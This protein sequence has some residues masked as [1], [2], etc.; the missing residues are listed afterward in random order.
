MKITLSLI[1]ITTL[2][3]SQK[4]Y[5]LGKMDVKGGQKGRAAMATARLFFENFLWDHGVDPFIPVNDLSHPQID[6]D[7]G[8]GIRIIRG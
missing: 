7:A 5:G 4:L 3:I 2:P 6:S 8:E 1:L